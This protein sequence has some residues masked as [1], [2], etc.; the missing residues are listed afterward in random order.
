MSNES[1]RYVFNDNAKWSKVI[2]CMPYVLREIEIS[3]KDNKGKSHKTNLSGDE[4]DFLLVVIMAYDMNALQYKQA[5]ECI[6]MLSYEDIARQLKCSRS[7]AYRICS[8]LIENKLLICSN[9]DNRKG[10]SKSAY[11]PN[12]ETLQKHIKNYLEKY[13]EYKI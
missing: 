12:V 2:L 10:T 5:D 7:K 6:T 9:K 8:R 3:I 13:P 4:R 1:K 11:I